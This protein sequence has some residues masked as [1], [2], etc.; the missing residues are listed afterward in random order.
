[1]LSIIYTVVQVPVRYLYWYLYYPYRTGSTTVH[2]VLKN[3]QYRY[4]TLHVQL[5]HIRF[6][7]M[8]YQLNILLALNEITKKRYRYP[9]TLLPAQVRV[10]L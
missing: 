9:G 8:F 2:V 4:S 1:M 3:V 5:P 10:L 7:V 6:R